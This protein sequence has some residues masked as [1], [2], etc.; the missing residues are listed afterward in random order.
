MSRVLTPKNIAIVLSSLI[1]FAL[2]SHV[3]MIAGIIVLVFV[4]TAAGT[5]Y[6]WVRNVKIAVVLVLIALAFGTT[7]AAGADR[8]SSRLVS[9]ELARL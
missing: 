4:S 9:I 5:S 2:V 3:N 7:I 1:G 6:S 8:A